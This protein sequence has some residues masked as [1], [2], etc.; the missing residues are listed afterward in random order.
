MS[1][2]LEFPIDAHHNNIIIAATPSSEPHPHHSLMH[3]GRANYVTSDLVVRLVTSVARVCAK[4]RDID[5][6]WSEFE[7]K[8]PRLA[9][10]YMKY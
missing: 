9:S 5:L 4:V 1:E 10:Y 3:A 6:I 8:Q 7:A 2:C